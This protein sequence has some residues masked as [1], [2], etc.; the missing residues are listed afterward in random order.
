MGMEEEYAWVIDFLPGGRSS[1]RSGEPIAQLVGERFFTLFEVSVK[2]GHILSFGQRIY[3][4][5]AE[6]AEV[7][8]IKKRLS[9]EE[10]TGTARTELPNCLAKILQYRETDFVGFFNKAGP[11]SV[12]LHQL[13]L[14]NGIGKRHLT[15]IL[16]AREQKA[17]ESL[18][19]IHA[20]LPLMPDPTQLLVN[21]IMDEMQAKVHQHYLFV[22]PPRAEDR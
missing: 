15:Q 8:R 21:R 19:D 5:Q 3:I 11:L 22:R 2:P 17:F 7:D 1:E 13:E 10:L 12:R 16:E 20:R 14:I 9:F 6:R 18:A 4:G